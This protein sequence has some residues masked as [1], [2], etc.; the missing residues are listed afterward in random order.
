MLAP[1][2]IKSESET[3]FSAGKNTNSSSELKFITELGRSLLFTVHPKKVASRVA[4]AIGRETA[5]PI[6]AVVVELEHIGLISGAFMLGT[7][8]NKS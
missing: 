4:E 3:Y 2:R 5:A 7:S 8:S 6:C 1:K